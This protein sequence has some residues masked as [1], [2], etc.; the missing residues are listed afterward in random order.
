MWSWRVLEKDLMFKGLGNKNIGS[1][2]HLMV[3][4]VWKR[5]VEWE[6]KKDKY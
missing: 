4:L 2:R 5:W 6:I 1:W 3:F